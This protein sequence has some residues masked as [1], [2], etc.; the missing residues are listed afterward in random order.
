MGINFL[1]ESLT[2]VRQPS[3]EYK[4]FI[5]N[6]AQKIYVTPTEF[7]TTNF[8][9]IFTNT[10]IKHTSGAEAKRWLSG[11][12]MSYWPQQLNFALW[13]ATTGSG[14]SRD[15]LLSSTSLELTSQLLFFCFCFTFTSQ[16]DKYCLK[17]VEFK[18]LVLCQVIPHSARQ[19]T[20]TAL[21]NSGE[22]ALSLVLIQAVTFATNAARIMG[23]VM[24]LSMFP[25][26]AIKPNS[27]TTVVAPATA[28]LCISSETMMALQSS[29]SLLCQIFHRA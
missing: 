9:Q 28:T 13:C 10:K 20:P 15:I 26:Q 12:N 25:A 2:S 6:K 11:P 29:L 1:H 27:V 23:L 21:H 3:H 7:F 5:L 17:W 14:I 19:T 22:S 24:C 16:Q 18:A 4:C 8:R